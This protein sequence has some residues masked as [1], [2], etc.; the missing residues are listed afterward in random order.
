M[1]RCSRAWSSGQCAKGAPMLLGMLPVYLDE[2]PA[3]FLR[4]AKRVVSL[5]CAE[6]MAHY[7]IPHCG[8]SGNGTGW[9]MDFPARRGSILDEH[10]D[11][12]SHEGQH[13]SVHRRAL[14]SKAVSPLTFIYCHE[15]IDQACAS[16][17]D[18]NGLYQRRLE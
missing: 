18:F 13:R 7:G 8:T 6:M 2:N 9:G 5:A 3:K 17:A 4:P 11:D 10:A 15:I 16:Q 1:A 12:D 14:G